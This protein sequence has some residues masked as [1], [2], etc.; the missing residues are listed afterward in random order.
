[1]N[2]QIYDLIGVTEKEYLNWC[3]ENKKSALKIE[4]KREFFKKITNEQ[5]VR[6]SVTGNIIK[7][8]K[9]TK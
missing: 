9:K 7:K 1:M 4:T 5:L 3:K 6:D 8:R 2:K